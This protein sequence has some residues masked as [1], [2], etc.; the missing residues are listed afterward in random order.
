MTVADDKSLQFEASDGRCL[1]AGSAGTGRER[2][3]ASRCEPRRR[4]SP[5]MRRG[6]SASRPCLCRAAH[7]C[8]HRSTN[9]SWHQGRR[10]V[11][12]RPCAPRRDSPVA[13]MSVRWWSTIARRHPMRRLPRY[14]PADTRPRRPGIRRRRGR[15]QGVPPRP[16][17]VVSALKLLIG[18]ALVEVGWFLDD[19]RGESHPAC[20]AGAWHPGLA[21]DRP[22]HRWRRRCGGGGRNPM[23]SWSSRASWR[24]ANSPTFALVPY[25]PERW[26]HGMGHH[27]AMVF[28][29]RRTTVLDVRAARR[30]PRIA[31]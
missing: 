2:T 7:T 5:M 11:C 15:P 19:P 9:P 4:P 12:S 21:A 26:P 3:A 31:R 14:A 28:W 29:D 23:I 30:S 13:S 24:L 8:L 17:R 10:P 20:G 25:P 16:A 22:G 18:E 6:G 27:I 1:Y